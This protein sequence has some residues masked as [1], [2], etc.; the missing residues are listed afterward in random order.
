MNDVEEV[1][2]DQLKGDEDSNDFRKV[3]YERPC[4]S[5][6]KVELAR[7]LFDLKEFRKCAHILQEETSQTAIF[8]RS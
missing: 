7:T 5:N 2:S 1:P 4:R 3:F 6:D 8:L